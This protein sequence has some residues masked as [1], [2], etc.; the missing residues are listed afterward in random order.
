[1]LFGNIF[2]C[3]FIEMEYYSNFV[4]VHGDGDDTKVECSLHFVFVF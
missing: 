3:H 4:A 1:M 2:C